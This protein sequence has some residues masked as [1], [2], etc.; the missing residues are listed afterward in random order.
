VRRKLTA[1]H[2]SW[3]LAKPFRISRAVKVV[4]DVVVVEIRQGAARGWG[5]AV[6]YARYGETVASVLAA[7]AEVP[8]DIEHGMSRT[9]L[10]QVMPPGAARNAIDCALWDLEAG[11][12]GTSVTRSLGLG[13]VPP[14][15]G[16]LTIGIDTPDAMHQAA[17][18]LGSA[19]VLKIKV[20]ADAPEAQLRAV[21][22]AAPH[23]RLI[24]DANEGWSIDLLDHMQSV[25]IEMRVDLVEQPLPADDDGDL[26][27]FESAQP[28]CAD[29]S[30]HVAADLP[31]LAGRY[32]AVN[33]KLDKTGGLTEALALLRAARA[34]GF[35][36]MSGCMVCTSLGVAPAFHVA[37][38]A[39]FVDLDGPIL[40][41]RDRPGGARLE[42]G[43]LLAPAEALWG[44]GVPTR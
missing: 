21:R 19:P 35:G 37:R 6:P 11:L 40:L 2:E 28:I 24:V 29:E 10:Q 9:E 39:D 7:I 13:P 25:M 31:R 41:R 33:I 3:P 1:S 20:N 15:D 26:D 32:G 42:S 38:H 44:G 16:A 43:K 12:S 5:E 23:A 8:A 22:A 4:A 14:L 17:L 30:C 27:G 34:A 18:A 36:V